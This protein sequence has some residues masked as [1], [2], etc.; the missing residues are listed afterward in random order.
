MDFAVAIQ[1]KNKISEILGSRKD[2]KLYKDYS[3]A[4]QVD[5]DG[6]EGRT[7]D[8]IVT[9]TKCELIPKLKDLLGKEA[10][11]AVIKEIDV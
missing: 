9:A 3:V 4:L 7:F 6:P 11:G 2:L 10:E 8:V 1:K 5:N